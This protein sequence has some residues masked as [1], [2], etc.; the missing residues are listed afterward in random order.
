MLNGWS[1]GQ[2]N[3]PG[4]T[5]AL[6][7]ECS[8]FIQQ[9]DIFALTGDLASGKTTFVKGVLEGLGYKEEVTSPTFTLINE[10]HAK[11]SIIHIDCYRE[12]NL[13][14]WNNLGINEYLFSDKI[15]FIEWAEIIKEIL[16]DD[17]ISIYFLNLG[18]DQREI[19]CQH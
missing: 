10:Y 3:S 9:G 15:V 2:T 11:S 1:G 8:S 12:S 4:E 7:K 13:I 18:N 6:G 14:R 5:M 17:I 19:K 16:P